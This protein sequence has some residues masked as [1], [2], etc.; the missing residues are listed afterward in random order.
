MTDDPRTPRPDDAPDERDL[1]ATRVLDGDADPAER[2]RAEADPAIAA[3]IAAQ[4][5]ARAELRDLPP[6][7]PA[8]TARA[9]A[10]ALAVFDH[11]NT[12]PSEQTAVTTP[13]APVVP[14]RSRWSTALPWLGAAAAAAALVV[15]V[16]NMSG[17]GADQL[18]D[19]SSA[20]TVTL[21][22]APEAAVS[23]EG[24]SAL[25][26]AGATP[27]VAED[28]AND[29]D[30]SPVDSSGRIGEDSSGTEAPSA[31]ATEAPAAS[32]ETMTAETVTAESAPPPTDGELS[33]AGGTVV[34]EDT[35]ALRALAETALPLDEAPTCA[36]DA[37]LLVPDALFGDDP[38]SAVAV[39]IVLDGQDEVVAYSLDTCSEAARVPAG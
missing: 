18:A 10:A 7:D 17:G 8:V 16:A 32:P 39:E 20:D 2:A 38:A 29:A 23:T 33:V 1:L 14:L 36:P 21:S 24:G 25:D 37:T 27:M 13:L 22:A 9:V 34:V 31:P 26:D 19:T 12:I 4:A 6:V 5:R 35:D 3:R 15:G 11:E 30:A 28:G